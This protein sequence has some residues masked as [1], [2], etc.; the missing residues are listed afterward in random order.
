MGT[1]TELVTAIRPLDTQKMQG[2]SRHIDGLV[3]PTNSLGRLESLAIQLSGM[4]GIDRLDNLQKEII[5]MCADH[6]VFDEG[7]AATPK[8]VTWIQAINMQK[9]LTGVCVLARN[10]Q[11]S[12]LPVDIG[13]DGEPIDNMLSL[14]LSRGC[15]NIAQGPAMTRQDAERLLLASAG[16]VKKRAQEGISVFGVGELGI[17]NTTPAS[18]IISV[19]TGCAPHD[20]VGIGANLPQDRVQHKEAIVGQAIRVNRPDARDAVDVLAKVGG[21]DL[22]GMTGVILGAGACGLPVVLDG[23]LSYAAAI[24]ACQIAPEVKNYCIPSHFSA[25]KGAKRALEHLG[26]EPFIHLDLRLGEGSG[27]ALAMSI[28]SAACAMYCEMGLLSQSGIRL[29]VPA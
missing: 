29:P 1:L 11:T 2:A 19:L 23:F 6:G 7:V 3:K 24:A 16:L 14:K 28:V 27:A 18:A 10:S 4:W 8:E 13:I 5:V 17:A 25:E 26:L 9:G 21:Y 12:V 15:G 20:V 22:V